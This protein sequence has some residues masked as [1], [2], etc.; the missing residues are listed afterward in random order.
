[1]AQFKPIEKAI[2]A[3]LT[4]DDMAYLLQGIPDGA[5]IHFNHP[6]FVCCTLL[7]SHRGS[8]LLPF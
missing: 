4:P 6:P 8:R 5:C 7:A 1:M 2:V 3:T